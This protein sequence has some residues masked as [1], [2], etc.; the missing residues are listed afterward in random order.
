MLTHYNYCDTKKMKNAHTFAHNSDEF[1]QILPYN[2]IENILGSFK[3][4][5]QIK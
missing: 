5:P 1:L 3:L 4:L 2:W